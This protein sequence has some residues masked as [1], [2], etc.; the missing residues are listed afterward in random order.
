MTKELP[1]KTTSKEGRTATEI[2]NW[3]GVPRQTLIDKSTT[4]SKLKGFETW[5]DSFHIIT[6]VRR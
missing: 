2:F 1:N 3:L 6:F 5:K 4:S